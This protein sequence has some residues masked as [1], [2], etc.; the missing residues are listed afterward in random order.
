MY[1]N[2][3]DVFLQFLRI[4]DILNPKHI[5]N[6][7]KSTDGIIRL[8]YIS[9]DFRQHVCMSFMISIFNF[10]DRSKFHVFCYANVRN[11]DKI[12]EKIKS[13][14]QIQWFNIHNMSK[15]QIYNLIQSHHIDILIDLAG[16]TN[17]NKLDV[18]SLK[19][20]PIQIT[21]LG[22]PNTT[23][24]TN[25]DFRITDRYA[26][27]P[28]TKQIYTEKLIYMPRCFICYSPSFDITTIPIIPKKHEFITFG[29][30]NKLHKHN[31]NAFFAWSEIIKKVPNSVLLIKRDMKSA[32]DI[33]V[34]H[35]YKL[36]LTENQVKICNFIKNQQD[37]FSMYNDI[38][39]CLDT[40]PYSGTTTSCDAFLMSTP[41]ITHAI[42]NR[43]VSNV[44][45]S[46]LINMSF[47][48]L[49]A[50]SI[51]EYINSAVNLAHN[52][53]KIL[54]YKNN[55]RS[56]FFDVMNEQK[57]SKEYDNLLTNVFNNYLQ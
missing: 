16:H 17:G 38:D 27:P 57:F 47:P 14:N 24:L 50:Y 42:P 29:V 43:H 37:Y 30:M 6:I 2:P 20:A 36:G 55:L 35:L 40:F 33:R 41:I 5:C 52:Q 22:Y 1:E 28:N 45:K 25:V 7:K 44:T 46:M 12:S 49:V 53:E 9:P 21:Y 39:I 13:F 51:D 56:K 34:K 15:N 23:G 31:K 18:L 3:N 4:N 26:D 54:Y 48:E 19:P 8:G 10:Y 32:F 11:E